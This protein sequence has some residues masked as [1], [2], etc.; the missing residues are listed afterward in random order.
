MKTE[1]ITNEIGNYFFAAPV[2]NNPYSYVCIVNKVYVGTV[3]TEL[4]AK[5]LINK[6]QGFKSKNWVITYD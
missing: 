1:T 3:A 6:T 4:T 2:N 5:K